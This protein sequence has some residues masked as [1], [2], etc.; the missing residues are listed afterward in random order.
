MICLC[1]EPSMVDDR[2]AIPAGIVTLRQHLRLPWVRRN[3]LLRK[4]HGVVSHGAGGVMKGG[5]ARV[6]PKSSDDERGGGAIMVGLC[7]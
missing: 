1:V 4:V 7:A 3:A 5:Y 2:S 6:N